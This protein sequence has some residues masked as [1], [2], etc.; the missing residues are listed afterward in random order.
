MSDTE[1][2]DRCKAILEIGDDYGDNTAT[3]HCQLP[4]G[5]EGQHEEKY[6]TG[7]KKPVPVVIRWGRAPPTP[8]KEDPLDILDKKCYEAIEPHSHGAGENLAYKQVQLW[9][10]EIREELL[11]RGE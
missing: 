6:S 3:I 7:F 8:T 5:H 10:I 11:K 2:G 1:S 4:R 9:I